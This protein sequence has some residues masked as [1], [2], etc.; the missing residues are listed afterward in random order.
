MAKDGAPQERS[1]ERERPFIVNV[2]SAPNERPAFNLR[3]PPGYSHLDPCPLL[4]QPTP[5]PEE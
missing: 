1:V 4:H 2:L 3:E 5:A